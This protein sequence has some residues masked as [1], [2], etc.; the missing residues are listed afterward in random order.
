MP[1]WAFWVGHHFLWSAI[2][3]L[4][5]VV[6]TRVVGERRPPT[7]AIAWVMGLLLLP[8]AVL[9]LYLIFGRRKLGV[10][11]VVPTAALAASVKA[12]ELWPAALLE[13]FGLT[14]PSAVDVQFH[15]D[16]EESRAALWEMFDS[17][18]QS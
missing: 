15:S 7:G 1:V 2:A 17:A 16:G 13:S 11:P 14:Q 8:Y 3:L 5:Y 12:E 6:S 9:P 18:Q 4:V 10:A